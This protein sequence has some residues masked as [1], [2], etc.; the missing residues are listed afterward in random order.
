[1]STPDRFNPPPSWPE[2]PHDG[3]TP[4]AD[5]QPHGS[6]SE[7]PSGWRLWISERFPGRAEA[8]LQDSEDVPASGARPR[9]RVQQYPVAVLNPGM[10]T[11]NH[12]EHE[13]F[14]FPPARPRRDRPRLR[15]AMTITATAL[16]FVLAVLTVIMFVMLVDFAVDGRLVERLS[17]Q[18]AQLSTVAPP[19]AGARTPVRG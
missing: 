14:G 9:A 10:W 6:W 8:P 4:P 2:P 13:T 15:L 19:E 7:V 17:E 18:A 1:M 5:F 3:W 16:G 12:L 11:D